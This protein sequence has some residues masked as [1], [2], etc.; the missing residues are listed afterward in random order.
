MGPERHR[1]LV[2]APAKDPGRWSRHNF[3][4]LLLIWSVT[5]D[6]GMLSA[7]LALT[8]KASGL[9]QATLKLVAT[10]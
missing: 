5:S 9:A 4:V 3:S 10:G 1:S 7:L 2:Q 8:R 6:S